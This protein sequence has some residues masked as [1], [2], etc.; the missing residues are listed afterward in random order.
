MEDLRIFE[1]PTAQGS[2]PVAKHCTIPTAYG[3]IS[4]MEA[5][6]SNE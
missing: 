2:S 3:R 1:F 6:Y 5:V 4:K